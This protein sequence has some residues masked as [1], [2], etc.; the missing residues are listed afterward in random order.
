MERQNPNENESAWED[1]GYIMDRAT[2]KA[3]HMRSS[4]QQ[5]RA[6]QCFDELRQLL[7]GK[8]NVK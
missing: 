5:E 8:K 6:K 3:I 7:E 4:Y 2:Q 1:L